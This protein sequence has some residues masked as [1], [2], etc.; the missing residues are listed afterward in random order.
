MPPIFGTTQISEGRSHLYTFGPKAGSICVLG[1]LWGTGDGI[2]LG[3]LTGECSTQGPRSVEKTSVRLLVAVKSRCL[4]TR[5][6]AIG[7]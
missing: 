5:V 3:Y 4:A 7:L 2:E 1:A 6:Q